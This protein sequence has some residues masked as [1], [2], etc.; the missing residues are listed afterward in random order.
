MKKIIIQI[1]AIVL[2]DGKFHP[3]FSIIED[4]GNKVTNS[5]FVIDTNTAYETKEEALE[6]AK[7]VGLNEARKEFG[8]EIIVSIQPD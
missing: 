3:Q 2:T 1:T 7:T 4:L 8:S 6:H 5:G